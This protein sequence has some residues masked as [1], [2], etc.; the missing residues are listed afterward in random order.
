MLWTRQPPDEISVP[1]RLQLVIAEEMTACRRLSWTDPEEPD[2]VLL[3]PALNWA[4]S[5]LCQNTSIETGCNNTCFYLTT[6][7]FGWKSSDP[8]YQLL[9]VI[10]FLWTCILFLPLLRMTSI[11]LICPWSV[12]C[13]QQPV[14]FQN[15]RHH[16]GFFLSTN[17][18]LQCL[19]CVTMS[20]PCLSALAVFTSKAI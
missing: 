10:V 17:F 19:F 15:S 2:K 7:E 3:E 12:F 14:W 9:H 1:G 20:P 4:K 16:L 5:C 8:L 6:F 18:S 13:C 11:I